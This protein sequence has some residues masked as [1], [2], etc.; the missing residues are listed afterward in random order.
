M[1]MLSRIGGAAA[2]GRHMSRVRVRLNLTASGSN[3]NVWSNKGTTY[4]PGNTDII[5]TSSGTVS[6]SSVGNYALDTGS[7]WVAGDTIKLINNGTIQGA[8]GAAGAAGSTGSPGA[9]GVGGMGGYGSNGTNGGN[10]S[11]GGTGGTGQAG[12]TGGPA[13]RAQF[14]LSVENNGNIYGG[15][16]GGGGA[17]GGGGS[18]ATGG[19]GGG[20]SYAANQGG[21]IIATYGGGGGAAYGA[22]GSDG[23]SGGATVGGR[24][25]WDMYS[26]TATKGGDLGMAGSYIESVD[27]WWY[28]GVAGSASGGGATGSTGSSGA[29]GSYVVNNANV[30]WLVNGTRTGSVG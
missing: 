16:G 24:G 21:K 14:A 8:A 19:G 10:A 7:G 23:L 6:A 26:G 11:P 15:S 9:N 22:P 25:S 3:Y 12:A 5:V 13:L 17:G 29:Q 18:G 4:E 20:G 27:G 2:I 1:A 28:A 30:T